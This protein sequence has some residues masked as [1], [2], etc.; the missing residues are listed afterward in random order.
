[1]IVV[2]CSVV[3]D[4]LTWHG[5]G[6]VPHDELAGRD[7]DVDAAQDRSTPQGEADGCGDQAAVGAHAQAPA[8][9]PRRMR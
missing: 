8:R 1:M 2:D 6:E 7:R 4:V 3:V 9:L 5:E